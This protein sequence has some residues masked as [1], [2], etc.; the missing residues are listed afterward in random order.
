VNQT[1]RTCRSVR[2]KPRRKPTESQLG[3]LTKKKSEVY[4]GWNPPAKANW[5]I[6]HIINSTTTTAQVHVGQV[7]EKLLD[8][9]DQA[10]S[11]YNAYHSEDHEVL[12]NELNAL[13]FL[14]L[15]LKVA[16]GHR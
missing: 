3:A 8:D 11:A 16:R 7:F 13:K 5:K 10:A 1:R 9:N 6:K 15:M 4:Y 2:S 12:L 14:F